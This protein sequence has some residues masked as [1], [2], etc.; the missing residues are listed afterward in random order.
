VSGSVSFIDLAFAFLRNL[1]D[2]VVFGI[3]AALMLAR[4]RGFRDFL[5][6]GFCAGAGLLI[7]VQNSQL[8]GV[9]TIYAGAIVAAELL[10]RSDAV[11]SRPTLAQGAPLLV[12]ALLLPTT[13]HCFLAL[14]LHTVL[15]AAGAGDSFPM[16]NFKEVRLVEL[17]SSENIP[18]SHPYLN[19]LREGAT[20]LSEL[21]ES[22]YRVSVLDFANPFTAGLGLAPPTGD[23][24][25][26]HWERNVSEAGYLPGEKLFAGVE[27]LMAPT[28][29][30][31]NREPLMALYKDEIAR[32]FEPVVETESWTIY[33][34]RNQKLPR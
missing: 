33:R 17:W 6:F 24:S 9:I 2:Y 22:P 18:D 32:T 25:W 20:A 31:I 1:S 12:L 27:Y 14:T 21:P 7:I 4:R 3:L 28:K 10:L 15:A 19:S 13:I 23:W 11:E 8:W 34:R 26:L 16:R 5:F 30:G 29:V